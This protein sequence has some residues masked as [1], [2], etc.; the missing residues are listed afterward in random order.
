MRDLKFIT[1]INNLFVFLIIS[2]INTIISI[3]LP[4][5]LFHYDSWLFRERSWEK[6]GRIY[7][8][9]LSVKKWKNRL[10]ELSDFFAF[11]FPKKKIMQY[12][13]D[14]LYRFTSETCR[15]EFAHWCIIISSFIFAVWNS[16]SDSILIVFIAVALN[17]PY[18]VIQRYNR[19]RILS[20]LASK[21][22]NIKGIIKND[23]EIFH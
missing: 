21:K 5:S 12:S 7:Q 15:A 3:K 18:I 10:P 16:T 19:P 13:P 14:Y 23:L 1:L 8:G 2:I 9:C 6:K 17:L 20:I 22:I 4:I 11:L